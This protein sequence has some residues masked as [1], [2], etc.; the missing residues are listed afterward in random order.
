MPIDNL[1]ELQKVFSPI[2]FV[3]SFTVEPKKELVE[4]YLNSFYEQILLNSKDELHITGNN[5]KNLKRPQTRIYK[6]SDI[7]L[8]MKKI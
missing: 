4:N 5:S 7:K 2:R 3:S 8:L 6:H 1:T